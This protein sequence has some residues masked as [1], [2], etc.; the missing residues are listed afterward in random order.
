MIDILTEGS[1]TGDYF[2]VPVEGTYTVTYSGTFDG[3]TVSL[4][5]QAEDAADN[6]EA[7][8]VPESSKTEAYVGRVHL[9]PSIPVRA[10]IASAGASTSVSVV[11][12]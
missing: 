10:A 9:D 5:V 4:E 11:L 2:Y 6:L 3:A 12:T 8:T 7:I 1:A